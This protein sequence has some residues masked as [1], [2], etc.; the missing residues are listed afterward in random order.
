MY[1]PIGHVIDLKDSI[2]P[3]EFLE[4]RLESEDYRI[5]GLDSYYNPFKDKWTMKKPILFDGEFNDTDYYLSDLKR[6][7]NEYEDSLI[8]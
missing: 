7:I 2:E 3:I 6:F 8:D 5:Q 1:G 4:S